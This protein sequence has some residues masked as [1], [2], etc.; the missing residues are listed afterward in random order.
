MSRR[1]LGQREGQQDDPGLTTRQC[2]APKRPPNAV[3][4]APPRKGW[5]VPHRTSLHH[6]TRKKATRHGVRRAR[7][8]RPTRRRS[9]RARRLKGKDHMRQRD[10]REAN[11]LQFLKLRRYASALDL[12][13]AAIRGE[14]RAFHIPRSGREAIGLSIGLE[15]VRRG[16]ARTTRNNDFTAIVPGCWPP[17]SGDVNRP[18]PN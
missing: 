14:P 8:A 10:T 15:F 1:H 4:H 2:T 9:E 18:Y 6:P 17:S 16:I 7:E 11:A 3:R 12:G 13:H 5:S